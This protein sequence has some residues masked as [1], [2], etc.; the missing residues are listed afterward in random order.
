MA[1]ELLKW[2]EGKS[3][4]I[5]R[6]DDVS[7]F[8]SSKMLQSLYEHAWSKGYVVSFSIIACMHILQFQ[9]NK[10]KRN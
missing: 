8:T 9:R 7:F 2:P 3:P 6:D 10:P 1:I 5:I 4:F